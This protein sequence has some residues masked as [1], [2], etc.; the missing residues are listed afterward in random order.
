MQTRPDIVFIG[1]RASFD[2]EI[3]AQSDAIPP[4][5]RRESG[6]NNWPK[7]LQPHC[8]FEVNMS[9][10]LVYGIHIFRE[11]EQLLRAINQ[12]LAEQ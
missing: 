6:M 8:V 5:K 11:S 2:A 9:S 12:C 3:D 4:F 10:Y 1:K 7:A